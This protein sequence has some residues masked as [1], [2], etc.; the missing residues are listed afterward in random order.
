MLVLSSVD[1]GR[2]FGPIGRILKTAGWS[3][4]IAQRLATLVAVQAPKDL[5]S[6]K[7]L[8]ETGQVT[9]ASGDDSAWVR[10]PTRYGVRV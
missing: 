7:E 2:W 4:F 3:P 6:L 8:L 10:L 1:G 9:P 5:I